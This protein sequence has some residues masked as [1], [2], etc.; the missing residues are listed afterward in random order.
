MYDKE[1]DRASYK[2]HYMMIR[3]MFF[4]NG[5]PLLGPEP[6]QGEEYEPLSPCEVQGGREIVIL[7]ESDN[8]MQTARKETADDKTGYPDNCIVYRCPDFEN[9]GTAT[10]VTGFTD[11]G[12][13]YWGKFMYSNIV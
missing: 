12:L 6:Y 13:A 9:G 4:I 5:W 2:I 3:P 10:V 11:S 7:K 8:R 1:E